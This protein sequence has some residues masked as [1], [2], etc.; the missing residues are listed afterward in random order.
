MRDRL[1]LTLAVAVVSCSTVVAHA[2]APAATPAPAA[3]P[4][5]AAA[6]VITSRGGAGAGGIGSIG[7]TIANIARKT[8]RLRRHIQYLE[9]RFLDLV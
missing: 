8:S 1:I 3:A 7:N 5:R 6:P 4:A 9:C 2:Q